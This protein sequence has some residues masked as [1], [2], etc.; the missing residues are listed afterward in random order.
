MVNADGMNT[1]T[2]H[3]CSLD[4]TTILPWMVGG[5][6]EQTAHCSILLLPWPSII[7]NT[8]NNTC[9]S[10]KLE[11]SSLRRR[12]TWVLQAGTAVLSC[13][14]KLYAYSN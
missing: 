13:K 5:G 14:R 6:Q 10:L 9:A 8:S 4:K 1:Q 12:A 3:F 11:I 2:Q 7:S